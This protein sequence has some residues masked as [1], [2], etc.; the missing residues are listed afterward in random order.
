M[1]TRQSVPIND[2]TKTPAL[3]NL[4]AVYIV[5]HHV[6]VHEMYTCCTHA[7]DT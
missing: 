7:L 5:I 2:V 6:S 3:I 1:D 4:S